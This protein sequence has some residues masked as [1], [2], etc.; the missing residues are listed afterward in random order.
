MYN[1]RVMS[2]TVLD[3]L[4]IDKLTQSGTHIMDTEKGSFMVSTAL[5]GDV[6]FTPGIR[7]KNEFHVTGR[8]I[9]GTSNF[10]T[11]Q[12]V[13]QM[14]DRLKEPPKKRGILGW[15]GL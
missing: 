4:Q 5:N 13:L 8:P 1:I 15:F 7:K 3:I 2:K 11:Q 14:R 6:S 9:L 10:Q 12:M